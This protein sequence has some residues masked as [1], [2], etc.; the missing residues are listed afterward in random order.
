M[1]SMTTKKKR[2]CHWS[3]SHKAVFAAGNYILKKEIKKI[4]PTRDFPH[5]KY[6]VFARNLPLTTT[7]TL[8]SRWQWRIS[9]WEEN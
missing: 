9:R 4:A 5:V 8:V 6:D 7:T 2:N 3:I 1:V